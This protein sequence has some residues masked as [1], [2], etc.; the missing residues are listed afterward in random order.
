MYATIH[1]TKRPVEIFTRVNIQRAQ[2]SIYEINNNL[3]D[4]INKYM[5]LATMAFKEQY[6]I[7]KLIPCF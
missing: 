2:G 6:R 5:K 7:P 3:S 4:I 1:K